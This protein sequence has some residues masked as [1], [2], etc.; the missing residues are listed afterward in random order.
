MYARHR[1]DP[2]A[3]AHM[4]VLGLLDEGEEDWGPVEVDADDAYVTWAEIAGGLEYSADD[5]T[6]AFIGVETEYGDRLVLYCRELDQYRGVPGADA[7]S[8][9]P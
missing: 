1:T 5:L 8:A 3:L 2:Y 7:V 9:H 6:A 4:V